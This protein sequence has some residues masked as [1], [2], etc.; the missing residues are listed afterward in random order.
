VGWFTQPAACVLIGTCVPLRSAHPVGLSPSSLSSFT[1]LSLLPGLPCL[2]ALRFAAYFSCGGCLPACLA[3]F[4][5]FCAG[6][7]FAVAFWG[8]AVLGGFVSYLFFLPCMMVP[9]LFVA[10]VSLP[11]WP[12]LPALVPGWALLL[13]F[14]V[15]RVWQVCFCVSSL[16]GGRAALHLLLCR[17]APCHARDCCL[18]VGPT[19]RPP[20][21]PAP[22]CARLASLCAAV[23]LAPHRP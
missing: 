6:V 4:T 14:M 3:A 15:P 21:F 12:L 9:C 13:H 16:A 5:S 7:G 10:A 18:G 2:P 20:L 1:W 8:V 22:L 23:P 17:P 19:R 11:V